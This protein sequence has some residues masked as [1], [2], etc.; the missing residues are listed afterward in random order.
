M[1]TPEADKKG[2][3]RIKTFQALKLSKLS[4]DIL[5]KIEKF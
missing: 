1:V 2:K 5:I 3:F 4:S